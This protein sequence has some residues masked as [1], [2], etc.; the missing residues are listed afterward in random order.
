MG[1]EGS[2]PGGG[3]KSGRSVKLT[4]H[5]YLAQRLRTRGVMLPLPHTSSWRSVQLSTGTGVKFPVGAGKELDFS[6]RHSFQT[7]SG[8]HPASYP[9]GSGGSFPGGTAAEA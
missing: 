7:V 5:L 2:I 4:T 9:V 6:L 3:G 8:A 1:A